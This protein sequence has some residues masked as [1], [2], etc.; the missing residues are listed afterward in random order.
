MATKK[1]R[2]DLTEHRYEL[3]VC[4]SVCICWDQALQHIGATCGVPVVAQSVKYTT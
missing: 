1:A 2:W 3:R 4:L